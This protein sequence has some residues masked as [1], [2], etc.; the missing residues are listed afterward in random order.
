MLSKF[1]AV[2]S[3]LLGW[4][5]MLAINVFICLLLLLW[6]L[7][8]T[9]YGTQQA[10]AV[11]QRML[12]LTVD[13]V[14]G[15][16]LKQLDIQGLE[17]SSDALSINAE[18]IQW[19]LDLSAL[20]QAAD[21]RQ[22]QLRSLKI[23]NAKLVLPAADSS[24]PPAESADGLA[25]QD[26]SLP[27]GLQIDELLLT[28]IQL[29]QGDQHHRI[30]KLALNANIDRLGN[31]RVQLVLED[32]PFASNA[33]ITATASM[34]T[35][36]AHATIQLTKA[37]AI[38]DNKPANASGL[39][40]LG[41][42]GRDIAVTAKALKAKFDGATLSANGTLAPKHKL[43]LQVLMPNLNLA[44]P[45][46]GGSAKIVASIKNAKQLELTGQLL[47]VSW[48]GEEQLSQA[49]IH[50]LGNLAEQ[51]LDATLNSP[52][53]GEQALLINSQFGWRADIGKLLEAAALPPE[54]LLKQKPLHFKAEA[55]LATASIAATG[56][57]LKNNRL[58]LEL[59][60]SGE[61]LISGHSQSGK[62]QVDLTGLVQ[63]IKSASQDIV[64]RSEINGEQYQLANTPELS[65]SVSPAITASLA[66]QLLTVRGQV[67]VDSGHIELIV[68]ESGAITPSG[69][70]VVID[71]ANP[72]SAA[73]T[74]IDRDIQISL[75]I[76]TPITL[77]GQGFKGT[78]SGKLNVT[79]QNGQPPR[80]R[81]ELILAG[82]FKAYGQDLTIRRGKLIY[83]DSPIDDPGVD[84]EAIR[85]VQDQIAGVRVSG[86]ASNP[87]ITIFAEP[88]LSET[89][90]L[91]YLVLGRG[92]DDNSE[93]DQA[94]LSSLALSLGLAKSGDFLENSR[95]K[96]GVDELSIQTGDSNN[97]ASLLIGRQL[98]ERLYLS[99]QI[100]LFEPVTKLFLRYTL[101]RKCELVAETGTQ[102]GADVVC[103]ITSGRPE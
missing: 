77:E 74:V 36:Q 82:Q 103:T 66:D 91:S 38:W 92:L 102:Q 6:L 71:T 83:I 25:L 87:T 28:N 2:L 31:S 100:G 84:L 5:L 81:G 51:Q 39:L 11:A 68:P 46:L 55:T 101:S 24:E 33:N 10:F 21:K 78:A 95:D 48:L 65:L 23:N 45:E 60:D 42:N 61:L 69:D 63:L 64:L 26:I 20:W 90:A 13:T 89:E 22:L 9:D 76:G 43:D 86:L 44:S 62:G 34:N 32:G 15:N 99:T 16:A 50:W 98:S 93:R 14:N 7:L 59:S 8:G 3:R 17:Y 41:Y 73:P 58:A 75:I 37:A 12:P 54:S 49:D 94:Q 52:L 72:S 56:V 79:E 96:L 30:G 57:D 27:A 67:T 18:S 53:I 40:T 29:Q 80:A 85:T 35:D 19:H 70:V 97:D 4:P 47:N 1:I 88:A